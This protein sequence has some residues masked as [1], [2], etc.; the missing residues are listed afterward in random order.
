MDKKDQVFFSLSSMPRNHPI[1]GL[2]EMDTFS[3]NV[4]SS[5][6]LLIPMTKHSVENFPTSYSPDPHAVKSEALVLYSMVAYAH[7]LCL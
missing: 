7:E 1:E 3:Q 6:K 4:S 2:A 5:T